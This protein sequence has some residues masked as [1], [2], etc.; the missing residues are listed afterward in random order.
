[1][2]LSRLA[3]VLGIVAVLAGCESI[4][5]R[6][7]QTVMIQTDPPGAA[8]TISDGRQCI[9]P[10]M[11]TV[12]R[13]QS[14]EVTA[15]QRGCRTAV[16]RIGPAVSVAGTSIVS[17]VYDYQLGMAYDLKPNPLVLSLGCGAQSWPPPPV[18]SP[19]HE[20]LIERFGHAGALEA[21]AGGA[22]TN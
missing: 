16:G 2:K 22:L 5:H 10:C 13:Y 20:A 3:V 14:V 9:A 6:S 1:M 19:E 12:L 7:E 18:L 15:T 17:S 21:P 8:V 11:L 4:G